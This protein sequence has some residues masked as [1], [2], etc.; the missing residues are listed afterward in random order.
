[1]EGLEASEIFLHDLNDEKRI[2]SQF[3]K[4]RYLAEDAYRRHFK[5]I[6]LGAQAFITDGP[7]GYHVVDENSDIAMLTAKCAKDWFADR[8]KADTINMATHE[9]SLR[10]SLEKNDLILS[11]RGT[12]G[13][14]ALV[15]PEV[16]PAN[17]DQD[18][19][20]IVIKED[21]EF[22]PQFVLA[23]LNSIFGQDWIERNSTG[24]VQQ[25]L[26]LAKVREL[27]IP[28]LSTLL[29]KNIENIIQAASIARCQGK[30]FLLY[31]EN[32]LCQALGLSDWKPPEP[33]SYISPSS[34]AFA[35]GRLDAQFFAPRV[36][37]LR[38]RLGRDG[39]RIGDVAPARHERFKPAEA[40]T[41]NYI[42]IGSLDTDGS[43]ACEA[44]AMAEAPSRA[45]QHV[46][47]GDVVTSTVRPIRRLS[48]LIAPEQDGA[49]CSSGFV[50]LQPKQISGE[51]L[52]TYLRLPLVCELMD[53]HTSAT[54][55]PAISE[56][57]LLAL[58]IPAIDPVAQ[59]QVTQAV[60]QSIDAR[61]RAACLLDAAR[62]A[63]E[64]AIEDSE[65]AALAYLAEQSLQ[66]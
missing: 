42:E 41:F 32:R 57:D 58:P 47:G 59:Q 48:A 50:V 10:S 9:S 54:M 34:K 12:V 56:A 6:T 37:Q 1:M 52:L 2:D 24:M 4:K 40:G 11:T 62:R 26:S 29:Q 36:T 55:Y 7:H 46:R 66:E 5:V 33:L 53:L 65:A 22:S 21:A 14:C 35:A 15:E 60:R 49:V 13:V 64:I 18:V 16:L 38:E 30:S 17:I 43:A 27:P 44:V 3:F 8:S 23:Y 61:R 31:V 25:G 45:T 39:L 51:V 19:A 63:V 28:L 20:R